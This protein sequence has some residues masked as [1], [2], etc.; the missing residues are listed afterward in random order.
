[1]E[2]EKIETVC[3]IKILKQVLKRLREVHSY[4]EPAINII[5]LIDEESI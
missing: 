1:M 2:E 4:E 3:E 5:P